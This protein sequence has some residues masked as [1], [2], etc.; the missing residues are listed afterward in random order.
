MGLKI[1]ER[2]LTW[3]LVAVATLAPATPA[4]AAD[5]AGP[6]IDAHSHVPNAT[7][8]DA[9]VAAMN[10]HNVAKVVL[11]GVGGVQ[12]DDPA[13]IA[14][15]AR[16]YP[17]RVIPGLPLPDP[18][19]AAAAARL[20]DEL[21]KTQ[22]RVVGEVHVRQLARK[23]D[24]NPGEPAFVKTLEVAARHKV[25]V[26][27]HDELD[28]RAASALAAAL[29]A[30]PGATIIL[31]HGGS[32]SPALME[33][34]LQRHSNLMVDLSGMHFQRTPHLA[35]EEGPL[36][37]AWKAL[38]EKR[39][40]RFLMGID[41]WAARLFEPAML[42]RLMKWTRRVLGELRPEVAQRVAYTNAATL[43]GV[44]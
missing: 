43:F 44:K 1:S 33:A 12:K 31:A 19:S 24:R 27:I 13:W 23:I 34:L 22:A 6:L 20:E 35:T 25:P 5:Y 30:Q 42:D 14:A 26:V 21:A 40:D 29:K 10:R 39:P 15:A 8:V 9:Y 4:A 38:I 41:V 28:A 17:D 16:K 2:L 37:P 11:L 18:T 3:C 7:A 32:A 36:D